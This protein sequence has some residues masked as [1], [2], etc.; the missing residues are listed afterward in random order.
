MKHFPRRLAA[1]PGPRRPRRLVCNLRVLVAA[2]RRT[3]TPQGP[4]MRAANRNFCYHQPSFRSEE[5]C[6]GVWLA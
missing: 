5:L 6:A 2:A 1:V 4:F 3:D